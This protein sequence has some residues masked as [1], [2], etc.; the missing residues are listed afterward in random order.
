MDIKYVGERERTDPQMF[1]KQ[2]W[3]QV[4]SDHSG[5]CGLGVVI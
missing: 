4:F 5:K 2:Y 1:P 3:R